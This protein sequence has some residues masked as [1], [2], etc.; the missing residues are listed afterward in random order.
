MLGP[1]INDSPYGLTRP[2]RV[3]FLERG[4]DAAQMRLRPL[5]DLL[6]SAGQISGYAVVDRD[7]SI[8]GDVAE[9]YDVVL[10]H[11]IPSSRQLNWLRRIAPQVAYDI[12]DLLLPG[13]GERVRGRRAIDAESVA[14]CLNNA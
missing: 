12:D 1:E 6:R 9:R 5:L 11:R 4:G 7:P 13:R 2:F 14:W 3:L 10:A 8:T